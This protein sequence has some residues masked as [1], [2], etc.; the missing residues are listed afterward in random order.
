MS[1]PAWAYPEEQT[2]DA[3]DV[4]V[5]IP[6]YPKGS[7]V[8]WCPGCKSIHRINVEPVK[9]EHVWSYNGDPKKPTVSPSVL[10]YGS[11]EGNIP[12]CHSFIRNGCIQ[13]LS[14]CEHDLAGK[15]VPLIAYDEAAK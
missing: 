1:T 13:F 7:I 11:K 3:D 5:R 10:H 8:F 15:T 2:H 14:D 6:F 12:R 4:F 9:N